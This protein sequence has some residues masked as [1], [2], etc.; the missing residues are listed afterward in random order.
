MGQENFYGA[1]NEVLDISVHVFVESIHVM[2]VTL[3]ICLESYIRSHMLI[4]QFSQIPKKS[5]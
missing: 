2:M 4:N 1:D 3:Q 5:G